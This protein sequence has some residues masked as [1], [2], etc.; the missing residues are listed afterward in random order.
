[1]KEIKMTRTRKEKLN[2]KSESDHLFTL[3]T[4]AGSGIGKALAVEAAK[5]HLNLILV[6]LPGENLEELARVLAERYEIVV[7]FLEIDLTESKAPLQLYNWC[8]GQELSVNGLINNAGVMSNRTFEEN[9]PQFYEIMMKVNMIAV[10]QL[11]RL[12]L[13][14]LKRHK[15]SWILNVGSIASFIPVPYRAVYAASKAFILSFSLALGE[16]IR[17][18]TIKVHVLCPGSVPTNEEI[19]CRIARKR[20]FSRITILQPDNVAKIAFSGM[21]NR[22]KVIMPGLGNQIY[23]F[24]SHFVPK[25]LIIRLLSRIFRSH[26]SAKKTTIPVN[27]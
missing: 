15:S 7:K 5:N 13:P 14:E 9:S 6:A 10:V 1:M 23:L 2:S 22:K 26:A 19:Q 24:L 16:E 12:F 20:W 11:T 3:I 21:E 18:S 27:I 4:G 8:V 25:F 17:G